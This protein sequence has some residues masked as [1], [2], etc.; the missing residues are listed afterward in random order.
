MT[1]PYGFSVQELRDLME[2]RGDEAKLK[3][4]ALGGPEQ[5]AKK[6]K[7]SGTDGLN[8]QD[9]GTRLTSLV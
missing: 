3:V 6:L 4:E 8:S 7:T 9:T 2:L 5:I 1:N